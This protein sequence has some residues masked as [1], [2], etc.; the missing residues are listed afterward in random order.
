MAVVE[1]DE[2]IQG[3]LQEEL[4]RCLA[5]SSAL[6]TKL[7]RFPKGTLN[8]RSQGTEDGG[9]GAAVAGFA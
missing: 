4:Q 7:L 5:A 6:E 8:V 2:V 3:L 9:R 1:K